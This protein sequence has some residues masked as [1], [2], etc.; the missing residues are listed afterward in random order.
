MHIT[1]S[2]DPITIFGIGA[3]AFAASFVGN[4][5]AGIIVG[6]F[7]PS[8]DGQKIYTLAGLT[9]LAGTM[10]PLKIIVALIAASVAIGMNAT[11]SGALFWAAC[12]SAG[13]GFAVTLLAGLGR[14][15]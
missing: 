3:L 8:L 1:I 9:M 4:I 13:L 5:V 12:I 14:S 15:R 10:I 7:T 11:Q 6:I 2:F